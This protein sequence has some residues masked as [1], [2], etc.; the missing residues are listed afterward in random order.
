VELAEE[1]GWELIRCFVFEYADIVTA[2][3][4]FRSV[5]SC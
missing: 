5:V 1:F 4:G 2:I 3:V